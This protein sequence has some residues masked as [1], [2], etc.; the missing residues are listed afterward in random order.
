MSKIIKVLKCKCPNC[1]KGKMFNKLGSF[2]LFRAP[3]MNDACE[4]C[5]FK[6]KKEPGFFFG[7][8]FVSYAL[9]AAEMIA[10]VVLFKI[11]LG[12]SYVS[13]LL[14]AIS[15]AVLF[16]TFNFRVSRSIWVYMFY[17]D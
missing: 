11:L 10:S 16:S 9:V 5:D 12:F 2:L 17:S 6:F 7:A 15:I 4:N 3:K 1:K 8:M 13:V 14:I